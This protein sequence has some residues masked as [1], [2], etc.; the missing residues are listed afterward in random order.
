MNL[1]AP[2][3]TLTILFAIGTNAVG[4]SAATTASSP[5]G[6]VPS[7]FFVTEKIEG[8][9]NSDNQ[10]DYVYVIKGTDRSKFFQHESR[11]QLDRNRRGIV[12]AFKNHNQYKLATVN[13]DCFS[14]EN[15]DGGVY[16]AP[17]LRVSIDRGIL[18]IQYMHGRYGYWRYRFRYQNGDFELVGYDASQNHGPIT[19]RLISI[20]LTTRKMLTRE[21]INRYAEQGT[22]EKFKETWRSFSYSRPI[23]LRE[24]LDFE[25]FNLES[26]LTKA[27]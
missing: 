27:N 12:V 4:Q 11:G 3:V 21:N 22:D 13:L 15:E 20:N 18:S 24:I 6:L 25:G 2:A 17:E 19:E 14:S 1:S 7:G 9:L 26:I 23:T 8:D 10:T 16:F 5:S